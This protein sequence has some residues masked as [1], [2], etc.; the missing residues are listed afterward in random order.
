MWLDF[1]FAGVVIT[2]I[3]VAVL[4]TRKIKK[5]DRIKSSFSDAQD[6]HKAN[7][8]VIVEWRNYRIPMRYSEKLMLWDN[9]TDAE[10]KLLARNREAKIKSGK[11]SRHTENQDLRIIKYEKVE[12]GKS[13]TQH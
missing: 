13:E 9:Y 2:V 8:I 7:E 1:I 12:H 11:V 6:T 10:K 3:V 4:H 5:F